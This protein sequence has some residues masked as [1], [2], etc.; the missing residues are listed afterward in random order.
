MCNS[1]DVF[2]AYKNLPRTDE[3]IVLRQILSLYDEP[4]IA[5]A[6]LDTGTTDIEGI[7]WILK[8]SIDF[9]TLYKRQLRLK[10]RA[11]ESSSKGKK[12]KANL[13]KMVEAK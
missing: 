11:S 13:A 3:S 12:R 6:L 5:S 10:E 8:D 7:A 2:E 1:I 9:E 4:D